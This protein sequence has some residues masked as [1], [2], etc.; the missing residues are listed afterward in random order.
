MLTSTRNPLVKQLRSLG[1]SAKARKEQGLFLV[2]GTHAI[3]EAIATAYPLSIV[4]CTE[5]WITTN[6]D[7]YNHIEASIDEIE[8]L[9]I[10]SEEV[11]Q[12]IATTKNPDGAIAAALLPSREVAP[13]STLGLALETIQDPGNIGAII[14][15]AV[16]VGIDGMLVSSD[17]VDLTNP[18][19]IR[20]TAGQWFR[21]PMQT[22]TNITDDIRKLQAQGVKALAT[23]ANA[24][25]TYW[26]Y[27]FTQPTLI[28]LGN[29]GNGLS[30]E[31]IEVADESISI[32]Q[33]DRVE[34]LNVAICAALLLYEA[35]RQRA[36]SQG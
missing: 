29:E 4:C 5:K 34:S 33:S 36:V 23:L 24:K 12:A 31:L 11:L 7:L 25:K 18:K 9:E 2:E 22:S 3:T 28:L 17:S 8:R 21:C 19:I 14:R 10:V 15:S 1:E 20:A 32:P 27:D 35:K 30:Q 13:I 16:A 6:P 26:D